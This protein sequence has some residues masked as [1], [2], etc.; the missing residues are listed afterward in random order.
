MYTVKEVAEKLNL[1]EHTIRFYTDKGL[2]P[3]LQRDKNNIRLFND[4]SID[5]LICVKCLKECG[6]SIGSIKNYIELCQQGDSSVPAR[7]EIILE[8]SKHAFTQLEEA[9]QRAKYMERKLKHYSDII[10][11]GIPDDTNPENWDKNRCR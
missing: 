2:V 11:H 4:S 1:T 5:W 8:Q 3:G 7:Y 10:Q 6:M 9:K